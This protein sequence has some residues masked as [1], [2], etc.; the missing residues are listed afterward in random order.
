VDP[1]TAARQVELE[2]ALGA[3]LFRAAAV[4]AARLVWSRGLE[5]LGIDPL[6]P[7]RL[8]VTAGG[9]ILSRRDPWTNA[10]RHTA[11]AF[12]A[13][14]GGADVVRLPAFDARTGES[15]AARR[16]A[17]NAPLILREEAALGGSPI[18]RE[19]QYATRPPDCSPSGCG[20]AANSMV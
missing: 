6:V 13:A 3:D 16:L 14:V 2:L 1:A 7:P 5:L 9:R 8:V 12:A 15:P 4:R 18:R 20:R 19:A 10:L 17:R 11:V